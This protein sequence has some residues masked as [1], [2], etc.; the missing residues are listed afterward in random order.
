MNKVHIH[1]RLKFFHI[2]KNCA[3]FQEHLS[4]VFMNNDDNPLKLR[5]LEMPA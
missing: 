4:F 1:F 5:G 2:K 3:V